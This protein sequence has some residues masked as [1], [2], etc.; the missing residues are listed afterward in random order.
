MRKKLQWLGNSRVLL[1][2]RSVLGVF[3][4][5]GDFDQ[6]LVVEVER[7]RLTVRPATEPVPTQA[8]ETTVQLPAFETLKPREQAILRELGARVG[9]TSE[10]AERVGGASVPTFSLALNRLLRAGWL[11]KVGRDW[12]LTI[13]ARKQ[14][15]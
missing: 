3:L 4:P 6:E 12:H 9:N 8:R 1:L 5:D 10:V 14:L 2:D 13:A 7:G 11:R 15:S